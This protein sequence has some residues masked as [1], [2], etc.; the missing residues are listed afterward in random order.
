LNIA[1]NNLTLTRES[2][3]AG[4]VGVL[5]ILE[6]ERSVQRARIGVAG[7]HAQQLQDSAELIVALGGDSPLA[8]PATASTSP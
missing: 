8:P 4:N 7:A 1:E 6:A 3:S 2:Y 5:Q